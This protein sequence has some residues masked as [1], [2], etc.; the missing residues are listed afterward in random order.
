MRKTPRF[1]RRPSGPSG[2]LAFLGVILTVGCEG[3]L[4]VDDSAVVL[5]GDLEAA[6]PGGISALVRGMVGNYHETV[7]NIALYSGLLTDEMVSAGTF[8]DRL[9]VDARRI[10]PGSLALSGI[11]G[12]LHLTR[13]Q[14]DTTLVQLEARLSDPRFE[15]ALDELREGIAL[16]KL[17]GGYSRI[18][19][20]E[21]YCW[22]ILTG[23]AFEPAPLLPDARMQQVI[24]VLQEAEARA[25]EIDLDD[26]RLAA[27]VGQARAHL[28][29]RS[30]QQA[31]ALAAQVDRDFVYWSEYSQNNPSQY[32]E[33]Y[34]LT[35]GDTELIRWT[36][37]DGSL[38]QE[39][40]GERWEHLDQFLALNLLRDRPEGFRAQSSASFPVVLQTLYSRPESD[41]LMASGVEAVLIRA[42]AA[43]RS[44]DTGGA[45]ALLND[46]R[47]DYS[48]RA[49]LRWRVELPEEDS[50]LLPIELSGNLAADLKRVADERARELWLTGDR[51]TTARR[52]RLDP[53]TS[54]DL[55]PP[56]R[57]AGGDDIAYPMHL[58]ELDRNPNLSSPGDACPAGQAVGSWR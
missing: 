28:W 32:N 24:T 38:Q 4:D 15:E 11:Y 34:A 16:G 35:W 25:A 39:A 54:I 31:A 57:P 51:H 40:A 33:V 47:S 2:I 29:R 1:G 26:V 10:P 58:D 18:W 9:Q 20:A 12:G 46:L 14:A 5:P 22:S 8:S 41:V 55:F 7:D 45:Q 6:G 44:G 36:V 30:Y 13:F 48:E 56:V 21:L 23:M 17:Y 3:V 19:L 53:V 42:E 49:A 52:L 37:G 50:V 43:V 27:I